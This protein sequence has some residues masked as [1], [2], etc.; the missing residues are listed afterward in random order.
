MTPL[1]MTFSAGA[2]GALV[3]AVT[4]WAACRRWLVCRKPTSRLAIDPD[5]YNALDRAAAAWAAEQGRPELAGLVASKLR[6]A[7]ALDR[8]RRGMRR[9]RRWFK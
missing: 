8:R 3:G 4:G 9:H 6:L 2:L 5:A 7:Y 1:V